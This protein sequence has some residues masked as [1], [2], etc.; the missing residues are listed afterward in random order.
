MP[1]AQNQLL[2]A[3]A[4]LHTEVSRQLASSSKQ[5]QSPP[6]TRNAKGDVQRPFDLVADS[7]VLRCLEREFGSG[8]VLSEESND[9]RFGTG[10]PTYR[11]VVDSV[12]GRGFLAAALA[13]EEAGGCLVGADGE[14]PGEF[15][16]LSSA[17]AIVRR[18]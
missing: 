16:S 13:L 4:R 2:T 6:T 7:V 18:S 3:P 14:P 8:I 12:D 11:F 15:L 5:E 10:M 9:S 17:L 1:V